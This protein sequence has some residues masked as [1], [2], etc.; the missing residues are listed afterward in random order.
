MLEFAIVK[1]NQQ[2]SSG[3]GE[4]ATLTINIDS[5]AVL[6]SEM[7]LQFADLK[8]IHV[9]GSEITNYNALSD[10]LIISAPSHT[11]T[12]I[13]SNNVQIIP[14]PFTDELVIELKD[15]S[16]E[17]TIH[18]CDIAGSTLLKKQL[19]NIKTIINTQSF[20]S[21]IY[22]IHLLE[23]GNTIFTSKVVK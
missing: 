5:S 19:K 12:F 2:A 20:Q 22:L 4:I 9:D 18:I 13:K 3:Y 14:N 7:I 8:L 1:N 10:T 11:N 21:G 6:G 23:K 17:Y 15:I 16:T